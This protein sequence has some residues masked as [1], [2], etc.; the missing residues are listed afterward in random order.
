MYVCSV[1]PFCHFPLILCC[2]L[3]VPAKVSKFNGNTFY[4]FFSSPSSPRS[5]HERTYATYVYARYT[6]RTLTS[7]THRT[8]YFIE[9]VPNRRNSITFDPDRIWG[10]WVDHWTGNFQTHLFLSLTA[11]SQS[12]VLQHFLRLIY[13]YRSRRNIYMCSSILVLGGTYV[14][15]FFVCRIFPYSCGASSRIFKSN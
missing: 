7:V 11:V 10:F 4:F 6:V 12:Y 14:Q 8:R 3:A 15:Q 1:R 13:D 2:F 9:T 5:F